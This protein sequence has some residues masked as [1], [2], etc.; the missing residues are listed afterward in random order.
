[1]IGSNYAIEKDNIFVGGSSRNFQ[2]EEG[3]VEIGVFNSLAGLT[4][5]ATGKE[6][7]NLGKKRYYPFIIENIKRS[8][9]TYS[10][11]INRM[12]AKAKSRPQSIIEI[13]K[14]FDIMSLLSCNG[15]ICDLQRNSGELV[16]VDEKI[17]GGKY[18]MLCCFHVPMFLED[19]RLLQALTTACLELYT[20]RADFEMVMVAKM[21][22]WANYEVVFNHFFSGFP[23]SC[24][25]VPFS[26]S[27]HRDYICN[28]IG[29]VDSVFHCLFMD[30]GTVLFRGHPNFLMCFGADA[31][32]FDEERIKKLCNVELPVWKAPFNLQGLLQCNCSDT[33]DKI[34]L[35][36]KVSISELTEKLVGLY[37]CN[38]G[39]LIPILHKVYQQCKTQQLQ[40]EVVLAY[41][42]FNDPVDPLVY[43]LNVDTMLKK[44]QISWWRL[45]FNNSHCGARGE[46]VD[47][48]GGDVMSY[49]GI[50]AY[51]FT[52]E[53]LVQWE[54]NKL[55][56]V[57][58]ESLL[59]YG[60]RDY[61]HRGTDMVAV[62][63]LQGRNILVYLDII[64]RLSMVDRVFSWYQ[65]IK[66]KDPEFEV[67]FV[68]LNGGNTTG[69]EDDNLVP[70]EEVTAMPWLICPFDPDHSALVAKKI[71][72]KAGVGRTLVEFHKDGR[73]CSFKAQLLLGAHGP[74][75]FPFDGNLR[76]KVISSLSRYEFMEDM[77]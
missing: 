65:E 19:A 35:Q 58:L 48:Y 64:D 2:V 36:E 68:R 7:K 60:S 28:Y 76:Q 25:A 1:M 12:V 8:E 31:F 75:A 6:E 17:F 77:E 40:F 67:V 21:N 56:A 49:Y 18:I 5:P 57:T 70:L 66:A 44:K 23:S 61:V 30:K 29:L 24:L 16:K 42:P 73:I 11:D 51:P 39:S 71:F 34:G 50:D 20:S 4:W 52:R 3:S 33:L 32:P 22:N 53:A 27:K 46:F 55:R 72:T 69:E 37:L 41:I 14:S 13:G 74:G 15:E 38:Q 47:L 10:S 43:Q 54:L 9:P 59:V 45:P 63:E 62:S 26:A